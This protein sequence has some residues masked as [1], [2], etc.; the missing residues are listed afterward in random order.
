MG[1]THTKVVVGTF[2]DGDTEATTGSIAE[3]VNTLTSGATTV[4]S[5][6]IVPLLSSGNPNM[7]AV[8]VYT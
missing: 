8:V 1:A 4:V 2:A 7:A 6:S 5:V 3:A